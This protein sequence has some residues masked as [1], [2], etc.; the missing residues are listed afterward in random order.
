[1]KGDTLLE[2]IGNI[3]DAAGD[4]VEWSS[5]GLPIAS[6]IGAKYAWLMMTDPQH[7]DRCWTRGATGRDMFDYPLHRDPWYPGVKRKAPGD[8]VK[9]SDYL[10]DPRGSPF[11][12]EMLRSAGIEYACMVI[13]ERTDHNEHFFAFNRT[14]EAGDFSSDHQSILRAI[15]PHLRRAY[16]LHTRIHS[17]FAFPIRGAPDLHQS[18][19]GVFLLD[20]FNRVRWT[21][22]AGERIVDSKDGIRI[23][24]DRLELT[25]ASARHQLYADIAKTR[26]SRENSVR[27]TDVVAHRCRRPSGCLP[28]VFSVVPQNTSVSCL[29]FDCSAATCVLVD[30]LEVS[31]APSTLSLSTVFGLSESEASV[32][33]LLCKGLTPDQI[34]DERRV[35]IHTVRTQLKQA[36]AKT[37]TQ[38]Q[39]DLVRQVTALARLTSS[40]DD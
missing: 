15:T 26:I 25:D 36:F 9:G 33:R 8:V 21:N 3:Y 4:S 28:Y 11:Y 38:S 30:D 32:A 7:P 13:I 10:N 6:A 27:R 16:A 24:H 2:L 37:E 18:P 20:R 34:A 19:T 23:S 5:V 39:A 12:E 31:P 40:D 35:S 22:P 1:M 29:R 17:P 14:A